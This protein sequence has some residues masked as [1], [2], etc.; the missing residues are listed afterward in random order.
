MKRHYFYFLLLLSVFGTGVGCLRQSDI[1]LADF[2][3]DNYGTWQVEGEAFGSAPARGTLEAQM[4]VSG[5]E[6]SR[7]ANSYYGGD[8]TRG[9]LVSPSFVVERDYVN[10]LIGGGKGEDVYMELVVG[11]SAVRIAHSPA[12]SERLM[13]LSWD[14][15]DLR[16]EQAVIRIVDNQRG[17]WGHILVDQIELSNRDK[18]GVIENYEL[19]FETDQPYLLVPIDDNAPEMR[20]QLKVDGRVA[21]APMNIRIARGEPVYWL[22]IPID[23][24]DATSVS[25]V[26]ALFEKDNPGPGRITP[27]ATFDYEY[28]EPYRPLYHF[29]PPYGWM[30]DPNGMVYKDG[31][32]HLYYQHNP[33]GSTWG[34]MHWGHA[35]SRDLRHWEYLP[36]ALA[37]DSLGTIFSGSAVVDHDNTAGFGAGAI[38]AIYTSDGRMQTQCIA[39]STDGGRTFT[40]YAHNPVLVDAAYRD[41][42]DPKV[43]WHATSRQWVMVLATTQTVSIYGSPDLKTWTKQSEFG[44]GLGAHGSVWE[45]PDLF[46]L[47]TPD[48]RTKWAM[49]VSLND[50]PNGGSATQYFIGDFD[51][52]T[53]R[54]DPRSYPLWIDHGRANYAGV[55]WNDVPASDGRRLFIGWMCNW[56]YGNLTPTCNF[57]NAMTVPRELSLVSDGHQLVL[58]SYPVRELEQMRVPQL[59][60]KDVTVDTV[61]R[62]DELMSVNDGA[63]ELELSVVPSTASGFDLVLS[64]AEGEHIDLHFD[65]NT[66]RLGIDHAQSGKAEHVG[67][68]T[69]VIEAPLTPAGHYK[70][71]LLIDRAS[72]ECFINEGRTVSTNLIF[73][74]SPYNT[75]TVKAAGAPVVVK[76]LDVYALK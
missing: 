29:S 58:S 4:D 74:T 23:R 46:P 17:G 65:L 59:S 19:T 67:N 44:E 36:V 69:K 54:A 27:A 31:E 51:G 12:E 28:A 1:V 20:V 7:L 42:R 16:G 37:P 11:D 66:A 30:N 48:G 63:Y 57:R 10:F 41:F 2:E 22:P 40:K 34:N 72:M 45:C 75:L 5:F 56:E 49:L 62:I 60:Q 61:Y 13:R 55:T 24:Y 14:V 33:Y 47:Q 25:L 38:V 73:P 68:F 15:R 64:N 39:Y 21:G 43:F 50:G 71:R 18:S 53:F 52:R 32:Y 70:V 26:F 35:V 76:Q 9:M 8:D 3:G 6:G